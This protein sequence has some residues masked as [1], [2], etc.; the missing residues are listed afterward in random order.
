MQKRKLPRECAS[1]SD[2]Q[3]DRGDELQEA[4]LREYQRSTP[5]NEEPFFTLQEAAKLLPFRLS[6]H[7]LYNR[8]QR[9]GLGR[10]RTL[11]K[12]YGSGTRLAPQWTITKSELATLEPPIPIQER[13]SIPRWEDIKYPL[14]VRQGTWISAKEFQWLDGET[15]WPHSTADERLPLPRCHAHNGGTNGD[16]GLANWRDYV[17]HYK[18]RSHPL[19]GRS[20]THY[21]VDRPGGVGT[22][23]V[24]LMKDYLALY[25]ARVRGN[26]PPAVT[27]D[28]RGLMLT[29]VQIMAMDEFCGETIASLAY[30]RKKNSTRPERKGQKALRSD[31]EGVA[32]NGRFGVIRS[33]VNDLRDIRA[34][35]EGSGGNKGRPTAR[36]RPQT[37]RMKEEAAIIK[38][39]LVEAGCKMPVK[40][41]ATQ[42]EGKGI[43]WNRARLHKIKEKPN[44][45]NANVRPANENGVFNTKIVGGGQWYAYLP[46][47][48]RELP[49]KY[50]EDSDETTAAKIKK[51]IE[52]SGTVSNRELMKEL[53]SAR[54]NC[55]RHTFDRIV[56][57]NVI[58]SLTCYRE[59]TP[60]RR[61]YWQLRPSPEL[62]YSAASTNGEPKQPSRESQKPAG[63]PAS[64]ERQPPRR[65]K[66]GRR[67]KWDKLL[68][69]AASMSGASDKEICNEHNR[70]FS[71]RGKATPK[72][73]KQVRWAA[74]Q[75]KMVQN[76]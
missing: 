7:G 49:S 71:R 32:T 43:T 73:L 12:P 34:G 70:R 21:D 11:P 3:N 18:K 13:F 69:V 75:R 62:H 45:P 15:Y 58:P 28:D 56:K 48:A 33:S 66:G 14:S 38:R 59:K 64:H 50:V 46:S 40:E 39:I 55:S 5:L 72:I 61:L 76:G 20:L 67:P 4:H 57:A 42:M 65:D 44:S 22:V 1:A 53:A 26:A 9:L 6:P 51:Y 29:D 36:I 37:Q 19:L 35:K 52:K 41:F 16:Q 63:I 54:I 60:P 2:A 24:V 10:K 27:H 25:N 47:A 68:E 8:M 30:W 31:R 23:T 17:R 74:K